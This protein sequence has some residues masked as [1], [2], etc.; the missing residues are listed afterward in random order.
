MLKEIF[1]GKQPSHFQINPLI[2]SFITSETLLWSGWNFVMPIFAIFAAEKV[3][4]GS[5]ELVGI[6]V[7]IH[8]IV[9]IFLEL[10]SGRQLTVGSEK[11]KFKYTVIGIII[12][13]I[14]NFGLAFTN[15]IPALLFFFGLA[16][17]GLGLCSPAKSA[18]FSLHLDKKA[19]SAEW[20]LYDGTILTGIAIASALGGFIAKIYG[21]QILFLSSAT[22]M[23]LSTIPYF[24]YLR[25]H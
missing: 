17:A 23:L 14:S 3:I 6:A 20:G 11:K 4:G 5:V 24:L 19:M 13:S 15:T 2:K 16:G 8:L 1:L 10:I 21:F 25:K 7:S 18:L 9:R 22:M 12:M